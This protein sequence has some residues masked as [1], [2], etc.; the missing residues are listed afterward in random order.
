MPLLKEVDKEKVIGQLEQEY[1]KLDKAVDHIFTYHSANIT[2][3]QSFH[4]KLRDLI[5]AR[6]LVLETM[7]LI[8]ENQ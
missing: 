7:K 5:E 1:Q 6:K 4:E 8:Q 2:D 3:L